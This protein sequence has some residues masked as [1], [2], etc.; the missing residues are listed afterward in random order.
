MF[1][2]GK[3]LKTISAETRRNFSD[4][5][6]VRIFQR[7]LYRKAKQEANGKVNV[8]AGFIVKILMTVVSHFGLQDV[9]KYAFIG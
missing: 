5:E 3:T 4:A 9:I 1:E 6:R 2:L 7:K 8:K